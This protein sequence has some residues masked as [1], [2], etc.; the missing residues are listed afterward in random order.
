MRDRRGME[1][2]GRGGQRALISEGQSLLLC[3]LSVC[4]IVCTISET[5]YGNNF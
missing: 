3:Y 5:R 2:E 4:E 1:A